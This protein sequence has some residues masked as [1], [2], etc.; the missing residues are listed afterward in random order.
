MPD[1]NMHKFWILGRLRSAREAPLTLTTLAAIG[2]AQSAIEFRLVDE[3]VDTVPLNYPAD[4]VGISVMTGTAR[5]AYA[6][7]AHFRSR[8]IPVV[9]GG[10]HVSL[11]PDEAAQFA[12]AIVI[13]M[14]ER[15]WPQV[16]ADFR[17][18]GMAAVYREEPEEGKYARGIPTPRYDLQRNS[19]YMVPYVVQVTRGC[20][21]SCD[22]CTVPVVWKRFLRR[23]IAEVIENVRD[24]PARRFVINDVSPFDDTEYAKELFR[25]L[26]PLKKKWGGLATSAIAADAELFDL[27]VRSGCQFLL[28]GFESV[29]PQA[30]DDIGKGFNKPGHYAELMRRLHQARI[31]VQGTFVFGFDADDI[32]VFAATVDAVQRLKIDIPRYSI[33]TP[34]PRTPLFH[35]LQDEGRMLSYNWGDYDTMHV[36]FQPKRMTPV[37]LYEGFR[38]AYRE[39]FR[40]KS[41]FRRAVGNL[42]RFPI[43]LAGNLTYRSFVRRIHIA[44][45]F[46]QPLGPPGEWAVAPPADPAAL[47]H[48]DAT[49]GAKPCPT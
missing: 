6:L 36:V 38:W 41:I 42:A 19:G 46:E 45:G 5:R 23:P 9:L 30:L 39:T 24:I 7:A 15:T 49:T 31:V 26:I 33:Y 14:A 29:N 16:L 22:F 3:S 8:G 28:I 35:R 17:R 18:G 37:E 48:A 21:H 40:Y 1:A 47:Q 20:V 12:D 13:G 10:V 34:Y 43:I 4:L 2:G 27:M 11:M 25:A 44:K 32:S